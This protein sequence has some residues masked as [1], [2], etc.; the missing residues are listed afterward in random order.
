MVKPERYPALAEKVMTEEQR[1]VLA[2]VLAGPRKGAPGPFK[3]MIRSP[4]LMRHAHK[5][6]AYVRFESSIPPRLNELAILLT[7]R[8]WKA[9]FEWYAHARLAREAGLAE[10]IIKAI[11]MDRRPD[12][13][14]EDEAAVHDF[15]HA[16]LATGTAGDDAHAAVS[17]L[18]GDRGVIDLVGAL[19]YYSL[20]SLVLNV[21]RTSLPDGKPLPFQ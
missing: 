9:Q 6:G 19:G 12:G 14:A 7:A 17:R 8:K 1:E 2:E 21:D 3:A 4:G 13:M 5:L 20:V 18:F 11:H 16:T 15:C 10:T